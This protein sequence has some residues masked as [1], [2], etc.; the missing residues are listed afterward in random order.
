LRLIAPG[1]LG[2]ENRCLQD[3]ATNRPA[4]STSTRY[5]GTIGQSELASFVDPTELVRYFSGMS[6]DPRAALR[7]FVE[8]R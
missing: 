7:A 4:S 3:R 1:K 5:G 6:L 2:R 8:S